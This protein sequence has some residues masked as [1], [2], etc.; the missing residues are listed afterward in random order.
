MAW[1]D[2]AWCLFGL[3]CLVHF[4]NVVVAVVIIVA[5]CFYCCGC[6]NISVF[7]VLVWLGCG[8]RVVC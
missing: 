1:L 8:S 5:G 7:L 3:Q 6:S 2:T 4:W